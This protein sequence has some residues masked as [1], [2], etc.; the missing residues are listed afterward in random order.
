M[1]QPKGSQYFPYNFEGQNNET[2]KLQEQILNN[3]TTIIDEKE[4]VI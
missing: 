4:E 2:K 3:I 1:Q